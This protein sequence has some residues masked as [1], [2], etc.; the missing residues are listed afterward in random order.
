MSVAR[1]DPNPRARSYVHTSPAVG[2]TDP[3]GATR[4]QAV[5]NYQLGAIDGHTGPPHFAFASAVG[6]STVVLLAC[7]PHGVTHQ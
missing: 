2:Y 5:T 3:T 1:L 6:Y 4:E 7:T